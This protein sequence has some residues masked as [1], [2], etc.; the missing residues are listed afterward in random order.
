MNL[1]N[2]DQQVNQDFKDLQDQRVHQVHKVNQEEVGLEDQEILDRQGNQAHQG[3]REKEVND[4]TKKKKEKKILLK[5][6]NIQIL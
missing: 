3:Y 2:R 1:D 4:E 6:T 5:I